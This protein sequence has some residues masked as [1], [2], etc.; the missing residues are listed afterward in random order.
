MIAMQPITWLALGTCL[1]IAFCGQAAHAETTPPAPLAAEATEFLQTHCLKCHQGERPKAKLD[2]TKLQT[3]QSLT[4]DAKRWSRIVK[5]VE[6]G[7]MPPVGSPQ[8]PAEARDKF[9]DEIKR[10]LHAA[11]C[12]AGPQPGP[13][14]VRRLNRTQYMAT[15]RDL[16]GIQASLQE[17]LPEDGAG[18]EGFD[19]AA[20]TL[21][22]SPLHA[23]KYLEAARAALD[24]GAKD[25]R[26][27]RVFLTSKPPSP[28]GAVSNSTQRR[29][30]REEA[31]AEPKEP[32]TPENAR[33]ILERFV[34]R[35]FRRPAQ[36]GEVDQYFV[37]FEAAQQRGDSYE[38]ALLF[39][40]RAILISP[41]F[42]FRI[43]QPNPDP[44]PK[45]VNDYELAARLSYFLWA[46][47]P[48]EDLM[49]L[50]AEGK[51]NQPDVL[52]EQVARMLK[53]RK[54]RESVESFVEQWLGTRELGRNVK[55]DR[56]SSRY[57]NELEWALKQEPVL[58][59]QYLLTE[60]R[61]LLDLLDAN[62]T[63]LDSKLVRHYRLN[64]KDTKQQLL[65]YDL[66][67]DSHRGGLLGM[68]GVLTVTSLPHRT[69]PV[70]R[71]KW[72]K[73][74]LLGSPPPPPPPNIPPL[75]D[76]KSTATSQTIR[77]LLE[78][79]RQN[80]AC[81][82]CHD[83]IDPIGFGLENYDLLGRWRTEEA[84]KPIDSQGELPGGTKFD[85]PQELKQVLL[86]RKDE[87][88]RH[89]TTK[90]LGY[91]LG[92]GLT[93]E[94]QCTVDEIVAKVKASEYR[95][96]A[97]IAEIVCSVPFRYRASEPK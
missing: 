75:D 25:P 55:P 13:A 67:E 56:E 41:H 39:A 27:R 88:I 42:L 80:P 36:D 4:A 95:S 48:D 86:A 54:T 38:S 84:G 8:P 58:F 59:F 63:F 92:R 79:H 18:G 32:E 40:M 94:D 66:P 44:Q 1:A 35:A 3:V 14:P 47:L 90:M 7:E 65:R 77:E 19:N 81:A 62:Y 37:L 74:T 61:P 53:D 68:A 26:S 87:F 29:F 57:T 22:L 24:Y 9:L 93:I 28:G 45:L 30:R 64:I 76:Q 2:L 6:A 31:A 73:E 60:N 49:K 11:I 50:A 23:E 51:L 91:A 83:S 5:R 15:L 85:G 21:F 17:L 10:A 78:Q 43:E 72:V 89:L 20:E 52:R 34:P 33:V 71:G 82:S 97:L 70:L 46:S 16:L 96:Q 12:E 69:S